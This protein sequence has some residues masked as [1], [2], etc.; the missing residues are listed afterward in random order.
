[1]CETAA[2]QLERV[3]AA[4]ACLSTDAAHERALTRC[5]EA[6]AHLAADRRQGHLAQWQRD[7]AAPAMVAAPRQLALVRQGGVALRARDA[8]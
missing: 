6:V 2:R 3:L 4:P 5:H 8:S 7:R 1:M